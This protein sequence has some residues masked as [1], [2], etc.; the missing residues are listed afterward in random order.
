MILKKNTSAILTI[1]S[2]ALIIGAIVILA[3]DKNREI[4]INILILFQNKLFGDSGLSSFEPLTAFWVFVFFIIC[5]FLLVIIIGKFS[6]FLS[7]VREEK[8]MG[9]YGTNFT[10]HVVIIGW[11]SFAKS[12]VEILISAK[13]QVA[14][15]TEERPSIELMYGEFSRA[16]LFALHSAYDNFNLFRKANI[17]K[18]N[19]VF[20]N[21]R[22]DSE[23]LVEVINLKRDYPNLKF[24]VVLDEIE[25]KDTF[26]KAGV[27][28]VLSKNE[29]AS[30]LI[31]SFIFEPD[32]AYFNNDLLS[33]AESEDDY[34]IQEYFV[35]KNNPYLNQTFGKLFDDIR[36]RF[37]SL[38]IGISKPAKDGREII[39]LPDAN[40]IIQEGDYIIFINNGK[41]AKDISQLF[42]VNEGLLH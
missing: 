23:N 37:R 12:I 25:L 18:S 41:S 42:G 17:D 20:I 33:G 30:K 6:N 27:S 1:A 9:F 16:Q 8:T 11:D 5:L 4:I 29:I 31:A 28:Y 40:T 10:N 14:V 3:Y 34:D 13:R 36:N 21:L 2:I 24:V 7:V 38:P 19:I 22:S 39:K 35:V 26:I 15:I 32:V